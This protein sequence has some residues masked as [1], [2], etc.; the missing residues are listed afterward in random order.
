MEPKGRGMA[1]EGEEEDVVE[2]E[3]EVRSG[4]RGVSFNGSIKLRPLTKMLTSSESSLVLGEESES[5]FFLSPSDSPSLASLPSY[6]FPALFIFFASVFFFSS[7]FFFA[8]SFFF[9]SSFFFF[10]SSATFA[11]SF[12]SFSFSN[13]FTQRS[14]TIHDIFILHLCHQRIQSSLCIIVL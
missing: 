11:F 1:V 6:A 13:H 14:C 2:E 8:S 3:G 5:E 9:S 4:G 12:S 10:S 7:S